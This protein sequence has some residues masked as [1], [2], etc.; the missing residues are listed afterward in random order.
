[1]EHRIAIIG[2]GLAGTACAYVLR[3]RGY[4][5]VLFEGSDTLAAGASGNAVG[6]FNPRFYAHDQP[7]ARLYRDAYRKAVQLF[8]KLRDI[9]YTPHGSLHLVTTEDKS[10]R[11]RKMMANGLWDKRE[12]LW[13]ET[14]QASQAA[15]IDLKYPALFL[16][17]SGTVSPYKLCHTYAEE[18]D[19]R[20]STEVQKLAW[21]DGQWRVNEE[22]LDS[23]I[24]ACGIGVLQF[25]ATKDLPLHTVRGQ[26]AEF[27]ATPTSMKLKTNI[28]YNGY[29]TPARNKRHTCGST[30]QKWLTHT[31]VLEDDNIYIR[32]SLEMN[33]PA[34]KE[35]GG[36]LD[37]RAALR[38]TS[39][40]RLPII[41]AVENYENLYVSTAHGSH[42]LV[43]TLEAAH[44]I[45]ENIDAHR[46]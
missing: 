4:T 9:D 14:A 7:E 5:P 12:M 32:D 26:I 19:V 16:P 3:Q 24:L 22:E 41:G 15:G 46:G 6:L 39:K 45:A 11:F 44:R 20:L 29:V 35:M 38:T 43:T 28:C 31:D 36:N 33:V 21:Q 30:F 42:G 18:C 27:Q 10:R 37:A 2:G 40:S 34:L 23:V 25:E 13:L 1:M 17:Q 8:P